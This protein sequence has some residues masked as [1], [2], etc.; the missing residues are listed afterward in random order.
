M[1][2]RPPL[3]EGTFTLDV[4]GRGE[5]TAQDDSLVWSVNRK[6]SGKIYSVFR[7]FSIKDSLLAEGRGCYY[8]QVES[9]GDVQVADGMHHAY[10]AGDECLGKIRPMIETLDIQ[11]PVANI[12]YP[13]A[14]QAGK[15]VL[16]SQHVN[17]S[18]SMRIDGLATWSMPC[19]YRHFVTDMPPESGIQDMDIPI[20]FSDTQPP[21][22]QGLHG[23]GVQTRDIVLGG[24][25][26]HVTAT[27]K[28][29]LHR[30]QPPGH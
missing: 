15:L 20:E 1:T 11:G 24:V 14:L 22:P 26:G 4:K 10:L 16:K 21:H 29:E 19:K 9:I 17:G 25:N 8:F 12:G 2:G 3:Y 23:T 6:A 28:W 18:D 13:Y 7:G 30:V 27:M 5:R